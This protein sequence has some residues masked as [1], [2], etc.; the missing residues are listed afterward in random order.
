MAFAPFSFSVVAA[1]HRTEARRRTWFVYLSLF[2]VLVAAVKLHHF[3]QDRF[4]F[5][6]AYMYSRYAYNVRHGWGI[7]WNPGGPHTFG[8]TSLPWFAVILLGSYFVHNPATLLTVASCSAG[9]LAM[10]VLCWLIS[11]YAKSA[12]MQSPVVL[13]PYVA[14]PLLL[15]WRFGQCWANGMET[16]LGMFGV[17]VFLAAHKR[18]SERHT[19][20]SIAGLALAGT[21]CVL[22]R[23]EL[24]LIVLALPMLALYL[25][26]TAVTGRSIGTY[27]GL[28][29]G[30]LEAI[31]LWNRHYFGTPVPLAFYLKAM[32]GYDGYRLF[33]NPW[34]Y[35]AIFLSIA[36]PFALVL[37]GVAQ[38]EHL[39]LLAIFLLPLLAEVAYL[40]TV[41]QIMGAQARYYVPLLPLVILPAALLV[42]EAFVRGFQLRVGPA[43]AL[44]LFAVVLLSRDYT[45]QVTSYIGNALLKKNEY[46]AKPVF[47]PTPSPELPKGEF[48]KNAAKFASNLPAGTTFAASEVGILGASAP[49]VSIMDLAGLNDAHLALHPSDVDYVLAQKPDIIWLPHS[50]Y[51][52][53]YGR[54]ASAPQLL[55]DY[56]L[57]AGALDF[58]VAI[59]KQSRINIRFAAAVNK[60]W[61][62]IYPGYR[63]EAVKVQR[64]YWDPHITVRS[65]AADNLE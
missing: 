1:K 3:W 15:N 63:M 22:I 28:L 60:G 52:M 40:A 42:D 57:Y 25:S 48:W 36:L 8:I 18:F 43:R 11:S 16:M 31:L 55:R 47:L 56:D 5:D 35:T 34:T 44:A 30:L 53:L 46:Y 62:E 12:Q 29:G 54:L 33:I 58:G 26:S 59:R 9:L 19:W 13:I 64:V 14:L 49:Q 61:Q 41:T 10:A 65:T 51:T 20:S 39:K 45:Q 38:R 50:D 32:H 6:D 27:L 37:G 23:P 2:F 7:S 21:L 24:L 4:D 17:V